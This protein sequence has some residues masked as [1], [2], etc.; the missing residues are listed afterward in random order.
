MKNQKSRFLDEPMYGIYRRPG[1]IADR[2]SASWH[3]SIRRAGVTYSKTF[4]DS[5]YGG[6]EASLSAARQYRD[7]ILATVPPLARAASAQ[8][9]RRDNSS[10]V[11]GVVREDRILNHKKG[12]YRV[13]GWKAQI[14]LGPGKT[15]QKSFSIRKYGEEQAYQLAIQA[16]QRLLEEMDGFVLRS[17]ASQHLH[18]RLKLV[19]HRNE[20]NKQQ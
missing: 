6:T 15:K 9:V 1:R 20:K 14:H 5:K 11:A 8:T 19:A 12:P 16:R 10:G 7:Q 2:Y 13:V 3:V 17:P 4:S 18:E